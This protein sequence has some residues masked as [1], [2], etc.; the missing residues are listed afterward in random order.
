MPPLIV[1]DIAAG[2]QILAGKSGLKRRIVSPHIVTPVLSD[3]KAW[4]EMAWRVVHIRPA[5]AN[6]LDRSSSRL[7]SALIQ[8]LVRQSPSC[9][10]TSGGP[11]SP[12]LLEKM[13]T[14]RIPL[15]RTGNLSSLRRMLLRMLEPSISIHGVLARIFDLGVLIIG[16]SAVGKSEAALDLVQRGHKLVA[17]DMV[18]LEKFDRLVRGRPTELGAGLLQIRGMGII[19]VRALYGKSA[20]IGS[21]PVGLVVELEDWKQ[22]HHYSL[23]GLRERRYRILGINLPYVKLPVK[24]GRNMATLI[25]V[26]ARNQILK[27]RGIYTA[28]D[29]NKRLLKRLAQ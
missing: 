24:T 2:M 13:A 18:V 11:I 28:R 21:S 20:T 26:A 17:D 25:E 29:L 23:I 10:L 3:Y 5:E 22:G 7:R 19:D 6:S 14:H 9:I 12:Q 1:A 16:E 8:E 15:L 27:N 4:K